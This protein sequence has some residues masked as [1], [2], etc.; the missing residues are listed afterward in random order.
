MALVLALLPAWLAMAWLVNKAQ[1]FWSNRPDLQFGWIV[2]LLCGYLFYEA[3]EKRPAA[4]FHLGISTLVLAVSA[5]GLLF[6]VQIY[7]AAFGTTPASMAGLA[8]GVLAAVM[9]NLSYV[10]GWTGARCFAMAFCFI[11]VAMPL[12][13]VIH[14]LVVVGLQGKVATINVE[15]L[16][17]L[18]VPAQQVG[19]LIQLPTCTVGIDEACSGIRSLQ[20]TVMATLFIGF[21]TLK[22]TSLRVLLLAGG[23]SLAL[24]G[25]IGRSLFL[26]L[27][28]NSRGTEAIKHYHDTAGWSILLFTVAG[29]AVLSWLFSRVEKRLALLRV[30][31]PASP[32]APTAPKPPAADAE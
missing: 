26:S 31:A 15:A 1:W 23:V 22:R 14:N 30:S 9:A 18:G 21:L 20:S 29:V 25:N 32:L 13:S 4:T 3:W 12:P 28:A 24:V 17:L 2:V 8:V 6:V 5:L 11:L 7:Q 16:N 10:F 19:S 27:A